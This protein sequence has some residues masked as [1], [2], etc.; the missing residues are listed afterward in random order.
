MRAGS[1]VRSHEDA[2][3]RRG[4]C[5]LIFVSRGPGRLN[6]LRPRWAPRAESLPHQDLPDF[7]TTMVR[8]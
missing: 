1:S 3:W 2:F 8:E 5:P 4:L 6:Q 7:H